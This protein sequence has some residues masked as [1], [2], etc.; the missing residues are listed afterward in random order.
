MLENKERLSSMSNVW[1]K[2][3]ININVFGSALRSKEKGANDERW[4]GMSYLQGSA[5]K[6]LHKLERQVR[7]TVQNG[8]SS[9]DYTAP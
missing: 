4:L 1:P 2:Y 9:E 5:N 7:E 6:S 3:F 8:L